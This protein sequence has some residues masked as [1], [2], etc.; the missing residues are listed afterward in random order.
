MAA[1]HVPSISRTITA[2]R[3]P[4]NLT[5]DA[6]LVATARKLDVNLSEAAEHGIASAVAA[7]RRELWLAE[8]RAALASS[9]DYVE[10]FGLPL[11]RHR[12][13]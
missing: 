7:R 9:N 1:P 13:F 3:Q 2:G 12:H 8:N 10:S 6:T 4:T 11:A 5:L